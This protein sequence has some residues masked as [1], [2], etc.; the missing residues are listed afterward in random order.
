MTM[1]K[2]LGTALGMIALATSFPATAEAKQRSARA[3]YGDLNLA[4]AKDRRTLDRRIERAIV[5]LC[6]NSD[7]ARNMADI[8]KVETCV[9]E[10]RDDLAAQRAH[11]EGQAAQ[12]LASAASAA[13]RN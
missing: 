13:E 12:R 2:H 9:A 4:N 7:M 11:A 3:V 6:G 10:A 1:F 8:Q 5:R